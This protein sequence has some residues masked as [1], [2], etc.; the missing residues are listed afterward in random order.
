MFRCLLRTFP[1]NFSLLECDVSCLSSCPLDRNFGTSLFL[2]SVCQNL[3]TESG[4]LHRSLQA[5]ASQNRLRDHFIFVLTSM[6]SPFPSR[7]VFL[8]YLSWSHFPPSLP[9]P[10][11]PPLAYLVSSRILLPAPCT[12]SYC[13]LI[14][15]MSSLV[16]SSCSSR[17]LIRFHHARGSL[18]LV[19][20]PSLSR[21]WAT[22]IIATVITNYSGQITPCGLVFT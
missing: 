13:L 8:V 7:V 19:P 20:H 3:D 17:F 5:P 12:F 9:V 2:F 11:L 16:F 10:V 1:V 14:V 22:Y 18:V 21:R 15:L 6:L 4:F